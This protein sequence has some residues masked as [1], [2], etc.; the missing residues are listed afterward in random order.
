MC[1]LSD[2]CDPEHFL[3]FP[4]DVLAPPKHPS[5]PLSGL[6]AVGYFGPMGSKSDD[7]MSGMSV[8]TNQE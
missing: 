6:S 2:L 3:A 8:L 1:C 4:L 5:S 7:I